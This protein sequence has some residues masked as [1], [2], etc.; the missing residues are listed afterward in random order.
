[1]G[2]TSTNAS[3]HLGSVPG[4]TKTLLRNVTCV[5]AQQC[6]ED[7]NRRGLTGAVGSEHAVHATSLHG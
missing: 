2:L 1:M 4:S 6:R 5:R 3:S 7:A